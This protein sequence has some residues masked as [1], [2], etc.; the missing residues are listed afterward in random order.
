MCHNTTI[1]LDNSNKT[2]TTTRT[3]LT[4]ML[5]TNTMTTMTRTPRRV[6]IMETRAM[7]ED[8][9]TPVKPVGIS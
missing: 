8:D 1:L 4:T 6:G 5:T 7:L 2:T 3:A 9:S